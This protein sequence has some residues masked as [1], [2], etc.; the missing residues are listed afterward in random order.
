MTPNDTPIPDPGAFR[1]IPTNFA[2]V[3]TNVKGELV[4]V[5]EHSHAGSALRE[6]DQRNRQAAALREATKAAFE[7]QQATQQRRAIRYF[8]PDAFA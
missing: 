1:V 4:A 5:S 3:F 6:A 2:V 8:E 7:R